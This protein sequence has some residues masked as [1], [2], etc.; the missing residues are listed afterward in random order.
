MS[1]SQRLR[2]ARDRRVAAL[3]AALEAVASLNPEEREFLRTSRAARDSMA[4]L[5]CQRVGGS[6]PAG[7]FIAGR[8]RGLDVRVVRSALH[9][10]L[11]PR[12]AALSAAARK[13]LDLA[14]A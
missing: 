4:A 7:D 13:L 11:H 14:L 10:H 2:A 9:L 3:R 5:A 8:R 12:A 1:G 6:V